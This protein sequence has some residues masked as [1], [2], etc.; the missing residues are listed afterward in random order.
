MEEGIH[1]SS[2]SDE[3][4]EKR[5]ED[6]LDFPPALKAQLLRLG[7]SFVCGSH[8]SILLLPL[9]SAIMDSHQFRK[10]MSTAVD[11]SLY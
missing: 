5:Y 4:I 9:P 2:R 1:R 11:E 10:A 3:A 7:Y 6:M 8:N